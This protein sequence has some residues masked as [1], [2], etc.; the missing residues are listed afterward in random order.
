MKLDK[1]IGHT[2][3]VTD[4]TKRNPIPPSPDTK[5]VCVGYAHNDTFCIFGAYN[6]SANNTFYV[7]SWKL[8]EVTFH[9]EI[10]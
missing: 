4:P 9:G 3:N 8:T 5:F 7:E 10:N 6:D 1:L 2:F